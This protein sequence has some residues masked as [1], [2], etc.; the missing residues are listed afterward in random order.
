M[1]EENVFRKVASVVVFS[2]LMIATLTPALLWA[3]TPATWT[4]VGD[5]IQGRA[6]HTAT[7]LADGKILIIGGENQSG[8][9]GQSEIFDPA[10]ATFSSSGTLVVPRSDHSATLLSDG[11]VLVVGGRNQS[12]LLNSTEIFDPATNSFSSGPSLNVARA[13]HSATILSELSDGKILCAV[14]LCA[15][16]SP[17]P[18]RGE[19]VSLRLFSTLSNALKEG[20]RDNLCKF[21]KFSYKYVLPKQKR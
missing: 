13:G 12:G 8:P 16:G 5:L 18:R 15:R 14:A 21:D 19:E 1:K 7:R 17:L 10:S 6:G 11:R 4:Q 2:L 3:Q 20:D 9:V